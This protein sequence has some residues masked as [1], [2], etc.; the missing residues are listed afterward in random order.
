MAIYDNSIFPPFSV[1]FYPHLMTPEVQETVISLWSGIIPN[2]PQLKF[3]LAMPP[4]P[5]V[6]L[7]SARNLH[8]FSQSPCAKVTWDKLEA[9]IGRMLGYGIMLPIGLESQCFQIAKEDWPRD[10]LKRLGSCLTG[11]MESW[12]KRN[13]NK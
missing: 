13:S 12:K 1:T 2:R 6:T 7:L 5:I 8:L 3:S 11:V 9:F 4:A 10:L